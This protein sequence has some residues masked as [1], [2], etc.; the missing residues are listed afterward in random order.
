MKPDSTHSTHYRVRFLRAQ[1]ES[2]TE[3]ACYAYFTQVTA[4]LVV[5]A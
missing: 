4:L 5:T 2:Y 3:R 1:V